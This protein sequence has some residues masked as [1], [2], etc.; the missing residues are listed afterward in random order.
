MFFFLK[1]DDK[2]VHDTKEAVYLLCILMFSIP[3]V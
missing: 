2:A 3:V 1:S